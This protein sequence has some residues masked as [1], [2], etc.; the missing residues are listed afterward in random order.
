M[1]LLIQTT[2]KKSVYKP[3]ILLL[4]TFLLLPL[5][6]FSQ[7]EVSKEFHEEYTAQKGMTLDLNNR[8]GD[9]IVL[10]SENDQVVIDV[11]VTIRYPNKDRAEQLLS[12]IDVKFSEGD[13]VISAKTVISDRFKFTGWGGSS[14]KFTIDYNVKMPEWM[15]LTLANKYGN[16]ELDDLDGLVNI[17]IKYGNLTAS[18][19]SRENVKPLNTLYLAYGNA[20]I[21][22]AGWM[23]IEVRYCGNMSIDKSQALVIDSKYSKHRY[24]TT[25]SIVAEVKYDNFRIEKINNLVIETG[26]TDLNIGSLTKKF[27]FD[28]SYSGINIDRVP[29]GFESIEVSS[30]YTGVKI[31]I[32]ESASYALDGKVSYGGL[33]FNDD[34]FKYTRRIIENNKTETE[35][36]VGS[37]ESPSSKVWVDSSYGTIRLN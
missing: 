21:E 4:T 23:N 28:G 19:L 29:A 12:Y 11:K 30:R 1:K 20:S 31:G 8:Y 2:M 25:S 9:I 15:D 17:N 13:D 22:E 7:N 34:N 18:R 26:Y 36:I 33:K 5:G 14:R 10:T 24:G 3:G 32:D 35:G 6:L 16:T 27:K 37:D